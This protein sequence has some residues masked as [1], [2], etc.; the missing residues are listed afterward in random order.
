M[1]GALIGLQ[2]NYPD[3]IPQPGL[4]FKTSLGPEPEGF[5]QEQVLSP[6][7]RPPRGQSMTQKVVLRVLSRGHSRE[8]SPAWAETEY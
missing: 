7:A 6:E 5:L 4:G 2:R 1:C 8:E 3:E